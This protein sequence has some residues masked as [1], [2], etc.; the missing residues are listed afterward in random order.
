MPLINVRT[1][2]PA[3]K[4]GSALLQELSSEL[5]NQT[6]KP[7]AYVMTLLQ[8]G[9]PMT[10]AGSHEP[11]AYVEVKSIGALRPPAMTAAFCELIQAR[12]ESPPTGSTSVL[13]MCRPAAGAGT[14]TRLDDA[15]PY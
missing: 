6:G 1:S 2:L 7:E 14:A 8:T 4:D 15:T 13:R 11:C 5:A 9:V 12:T 10:F 3:L